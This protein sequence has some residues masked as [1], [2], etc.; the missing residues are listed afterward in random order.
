MTSSS[1]QTSGRI[2]FDNAATSWP[3]PPEVVQAITDFYNNIGTAA[4]RGNQASEYSSDSISQ[5]CRSELLDFIGGRA[6]DRNASDQIVFAFNGTDAI[7]MGLF[8][9]LNRGDHVVTTAIEHNS[10]LRPLELLKQNLDVKVSV[11]ECGEDGTV[12]PDDI[13]NAIV[14]KTKLVVI[15]HASN[16][17]G[18]I[19]DVEGIGKLCQELDVTLMLDAAQTVGQIPI[20]VQTIGCHMLAAAGHKGLLGPLGT[21][22]LYLS[23][24]TAPQMRPWRAGGTGTSSELSSQPSDYPA[25]LE[26]GNLNLGGIAGMRAGLEFVKTIGV[27]KIQQHKRKLIAQVISQLADHP[28]IKF[29]CQ[30][31]LDRAGVISMNIADSDPR[32][33]AMILDSSFGIQTRAGFHCAPKMHHTLKTIDQGGTLRISPG[34]FST[35][36][37]IDCFVEAIKEISSL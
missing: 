20:D 15:S 22:F 33:L 18:V 12:D 23:K 9:F 36:P 30:D 27:E 31:N 8:G 14:S 26:S 13:K 11:V 16:V 6:G 29:Y 4:G 24:D 34:W 7:N 10:V 3:K 25:R 19:Q 21:G 32:E 5:K 28:K 17:T 37:E 2:Y 1:P 35:E